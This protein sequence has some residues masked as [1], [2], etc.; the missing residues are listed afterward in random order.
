MTR[1]RNQN[2]RACSSVKV[3]QTESLQFRK[4]RNQIETISSSSDSSKKSIKTTISKPILK[5]PT[6]QK[7]S[8]S[9]TKFDKHT[10]SSLT[11][12]YGLRDKQQKK[13]KRFN[14]D[15]FIKEET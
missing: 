15:K 5:S 10:S 7:P 6:N 13:E 14:W 3:E 8:I 1:T 11:P 12:K 4:T 9:S 2:K